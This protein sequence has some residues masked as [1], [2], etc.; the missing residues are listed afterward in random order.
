MNGKV[1]ERGEE[2]EVGWGR[3]TETKEG[4]IEKEGIYIRHTQGEGE[5]EKRNC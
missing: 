2:G 5:G 3:V 1:S 4:V